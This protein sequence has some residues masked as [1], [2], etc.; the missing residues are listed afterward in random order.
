MKKLILIFI[1]LVS[2]GVAGH[3]H[4][5]LW[6]IKHWDQH[7]YTEVY[8]Q[9]EL[10]IWIFEYNSYLRNLD[11]EPTKKVATSQY[12]SG[13]YFKLK[14]VYKNIIVCKVEKRLFNNKPSNFHDENGKPFMFAFRLTSDSTA[15][16]GRVVGLDVYESY[17]FVKKDIP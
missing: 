1:I 11:G 15:T 14:G 9:A 6:Q 13:R 12:M 3:P 4:S 7:F 10:D 5:G 16:F 8:F 2:V 17:S